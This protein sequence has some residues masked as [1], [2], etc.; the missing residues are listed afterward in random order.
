MIDVKFNCR[1]F[2]NHRNQVVVRARWNK[3]RSEVGFSIGLHADPSKWNAD[4]QRPVRGS[5]HVCGQKRI[6]SRVI[7]DRIEMF[8][9]AVKEAFVEFGLKDMVPEAD[10]L[11]ERVNEIVGRVE[12]EE[13]EQ[14]VKPLKE[15]FDEFLASGKKERDWTDVVH[16]KYEQ[17]W[18]HLTQCDPTVSLETLDKDKMLELKDWY[19]KNQYKN[20]TITKQ[21]R[22][23]KS[24][25]RW[26]K[27]NGYPVKESAIDCQVHLT[28]TKKNV[29]FLTFKELMQFYRFKFAPEHK[30]LDK[31]RDMFCFMSFTSLRYSDLAQLKR[32][33]IT[34]RGIELYTKK[35][36]TPITIPIIDYA[37]EILDKYSSYQSPDGS[38]F[39]VPSCQKLNDYIKLAAE[40]AG[41]DREVVNTYFIGTK[42]YDEVH[43]FYEIIGCHDGRRTF[44]CCSLALGIPPSVV[45]SCTGHKDYQSLKPYIEVASET[46]RLELSKW[47]GKDTKVGIITALEGLDA[48]QLE[49]VYDFV[50]SIANKA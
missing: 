9:L 39:P 43:K 40:Q 3:K 46:Q 50:K 45:M 24:F 14:E 11:R 16:Y 27:A 36:S 42:R 7:N 8:L 30:Y 32:A 12:D 6:P 49:L 38:L 20:R 29:T 5:T 37:Q 35:T 33:N 1:T 31:A 17:V 2:L 4:T 23:L 41:I 18:K 34:S 15:I 48:H 28:V 25:L 19:V 22:F 47:N 26:M 10:E 21:F 44:V 13:E